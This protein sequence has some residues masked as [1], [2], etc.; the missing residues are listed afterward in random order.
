[1]APSARR[2]PLLGRRDDHRA[3][4]PRRAAARLRSGHALEVSLPQDPIRL[5]GDPTRLTQV[6]VNLVTNAAKYTP[7]GGLV[8][9]WLERRGSM[10]YLH[11]IDNGVGM[12]KP[13]IESAFDLFVQGDRTLDRS[14]GGLG[15]GLTLVKRIVQLHGGGVT[16]TSAGPGLGTEFTVSLPIDPPAA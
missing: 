8:R 16:A 11:V 9:V 15:I 10:A 7:H 12:S 1:L 6:V 3:A 4:R 13:L 5:E 14:Q 2:Q